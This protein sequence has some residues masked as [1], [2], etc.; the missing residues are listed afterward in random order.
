L[1]EVRKGQAINLYQKQSLFG[2]DT[3]YQ[4]PASG[5]NRPIIE[6]QL[7]LPGNNHLDSLIFHNAQKTVEGSTSRVYEEALIANGGAQNISLNNDEVGVGMRPDNAK[8]RADADS[9]LGTEV[10]KGYDTGILMNSGSQISLIQDSNIFGYALNATQGENGTEGIGLKIADGGT[11]TKIA[12]SNFSGV[13]GDGFDDPNSG[14][15]GTHG[16]N[17]YGIKAEGDSIIIGTAGIETSKF[18]GNGGG[19]GFG[20]TFSSASDNGHG[21][22]GGGGGGNGFGGAGYGLFANSATSSMEI[23]NISN[24]KFYGNANTADVGTIGAKAGG[25]NN[26]GIFGGGGA[27]I[28]SGAGGA[29]Y[30]LSANG[31]TLTIVNI[32]GSQFYGN[33]NVGKVTGTIGSASNL[34]Y[35]GIFGGGAGTNAAVSGGKGYGLYANGT[36]LTISN[37]ESSQLYGNTNIGEVTGTIGSAA[38]QN[39]GGIFGGGAGTNA[40]VSGGKGYGLYANGTNTLTITNIQGSQFFGNANVGT[41]T[42]TI[43]SVS[44]RNYGGIFGGGGIFTNTSYGKGG[45]GYGLYAAGT[46]LTIVNIQGSQ[47]YG[48]ANIG[49]VGT[50]GSTTENRG[51]IFGGSAAAIDNNTTAGA[52]GNGYG[53]SANSTGELNIEKITSSSF[54]GNANANNNTIGTIGGGTNNYA[55][56]FGGSGGVATGGKGAAGGDG[57]GLYA[58]GANITIKNIQDSQFYGNANASVGD[59]KIIGGINYNNGGIFGGS[60]NYFNGIGQNNG[61]QGYGLDATSNGTVK[62]TTI[63][64]SKFYG[65]TNASIG[66]VGTIGAGN[67]NNIGGIFGGGGSDNVA[68]GSGGKGY[69]L[70]ANGKNLTIDQNIQNSQFYG[71]A[72]AGSVGAIGG[73][74]NR[75]GKFGD[76]GFNGGAGGN[77]YGLYLNATGGDVNIIGAVSGNIFGANTDNIPGRKTNNTGGAAKGIGTDF[78]AKGTNVKIGAIGES[79][80]K[81]TFISSSN[82]STSVYSLQD[83]YLDLNGNVTVS[84]VTY[85]GTIGKTVSDL[86][87]NYLEPGNTFTQNG[88]INYRSNVWL[89]G[90]HAT[91]DP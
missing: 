84:G 12:G 49:K 10:Y 28:N 36:N 52:G 82:Y 83:R 51:G 58:T 53:L 3:N 15:K 13:G 87:T 22:I 89:N 66:Q 47:F 59:I 26:G 86:L 35:G 7:T 14:G 71:N 56:I 46:T 88:P 25:N 11:I 55:G 23:G 30:G 17:G 43:G 9:E 77:G 73:G 85:D 76:Q 48:N 54:Y 33:A 90:D 44:D 75:G 29:G 61:G 63:I 5:T 21:I 42:G 69:G 64:N 62:I 16:G 41:V 80:N 72:N 31:T 4:T 40:A 1:A 34:N 70:Y 60:G 2:L 24:S 8:P 81:N 79:T 6:G 78:Y 19:G 68:G 39:L 67:F 37:I 38:N 45:E 65:N 91:P 18:L 20:G 57:Y 27:Y 50:I 32:Q 74:N